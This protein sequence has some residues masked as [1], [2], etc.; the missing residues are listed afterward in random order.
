MCEIRHFPVASFFIHES[1][2]V[3]MTCLDFLSKNDFWH[4]TFD[5]FLARSTE[6][7]DDMLGAHGKR[8]R[9]SENVQFPESVPWNFQL[10]LKEEKIPCVSF[11]IHIDSVKHPICEALSPPP[12]IRNLDKKHPFQQYVRKWPNGE[13]EDADVARCQNYKNNWDE[14][15]KGRFALRLSNVSCM[16]PE[17]KRMAE[18]ST[19]FHDRFAMEGNDKDQVDIPPAASIEDVNWIMWFMMTGK[20]HPMLKAVVS[21]PFADAFEQVKRLRTIAT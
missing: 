9:H 11:S 5:F 20:F 4:L 19:F 14:W 15:V 12:N 10:S 7:S 17:K 18:A 2:L 13:I 3:K 1:F 6:M 16:F 8:A 21:S